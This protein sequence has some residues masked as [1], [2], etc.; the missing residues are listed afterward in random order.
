MVQKVILDGKNSKVAKVL[1][2]HS[3]YILALLLRKC[4]EKRKEVYKCILVN[5][6]R[7]KRE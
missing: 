4:G 6:F 5:A 2:N 7:A 1:L 3:S